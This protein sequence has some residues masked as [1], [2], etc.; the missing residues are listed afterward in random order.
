VAGLTAADRARLVALLTGQREGDSA[1]ACLETRPQT[2]GRP[3]EETE[4]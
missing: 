4:P 1:A 2:T 3:G